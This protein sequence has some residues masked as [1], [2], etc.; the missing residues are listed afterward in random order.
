[1][2]RGEEGKRGR[3][4]NTS[5]QVPT[6]L[7][8]LL[9]CSSFSVLMCPRTAHEHTAHKPLLHTIPYYIITPP[10][11]FCCVQNYKRKS[12]TRRWENKALHP[13]GQQHLTIDDEGVT[14]N[15]HSL[16][17]AS[18]RCT[19]AHCTNILAWVPILSAAAPEQ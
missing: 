18:L 12:K 11:V 5:K 7:A 17:T 10:I 16:H 8:P 13:A 6:P 4:S 2:A 3:Q 19:Q 15:S 1:M 9:P 14:W